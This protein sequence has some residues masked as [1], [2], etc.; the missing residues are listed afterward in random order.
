VSTSG[1]LSRKYSA[2]ESRPL[3]VSWPAMRK[4]MIW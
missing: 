2:N 3:V 1:L 4:V